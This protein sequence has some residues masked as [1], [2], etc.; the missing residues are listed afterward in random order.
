[1]EEFVRRQRRRHRQRARRRR[2]RRR[3]ALR[4]H[5]LGRRLRL[6]RPLRA[7]RDAPTA[8]LRRSPTSTPRAPPTGSRGAA[9]RSSS[10]PATSTGPA[11]SPGWCARLELM[12]ARQ[13][14]LPGR[15][16]GTMLPVYIDDLAESV[17]LALRRGAPGRA[18]TALER[19]AGDLRRVLH[20]GWPR[21]PACPRHAAL[22]KPLISALGGGDRAGRAAARQA[23]CL[24]APRRPHCSIAAA[25]S[26]TVAPARSSAGSR[27]CPWTR[28]CAAAS[29]GCAPRR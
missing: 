1:M 23:S 6:R 18:Y 27:R 28:A 4:P 2:G 3:R 25:P 24:R 7:G 16:D 11:R 26:P 9:A 13:L 19:G 15:G 20:A 17:A 12:R 5:Q 21:P 8:R 29:A 14:A 10:A 22:P